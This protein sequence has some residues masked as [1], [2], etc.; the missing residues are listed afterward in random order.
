MVYLNDNISP[1]IEAYWRFNKS[2]QVAYKLALISSHPP[3]SLI[4]R[5]SSFYDVISGS[6][7]VG[8][9]CAEC[10]N[11]TKG[12]PRVVANGKG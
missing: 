1:Y 11:E 3:T 9:A 6:V 10:N 8:G 7:S 4:S 2:L 12:G 5:K